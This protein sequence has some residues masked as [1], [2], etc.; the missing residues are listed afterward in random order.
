MQGHSC[1]SY[2]VRGLYGKH[3]SAP[4][5]PNDVIASFIFTHASGILTDGGSPGH[6][7]E[8]ASRLLESAI[9]ELQIVWTKPNG[10]GWAGEL[11]GLRSPGDVIDIGVT[12]DTFS[13]HLRDREP[14]TYLRFGDGEWLS[15]LGREGR[16]SDGQDFAPATLGASSGGRSN[17][18]PDCGRATN[19]S[20]SAYTTATTVV[21]FAA[22]SLNFA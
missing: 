14:F 3:T 5:R 19:A 7:S 10:I 9:S 2:G 22:T 13:A 12:C 15:I 4:G 21:P 20:T 11:P 8:S 17:T 16:T 1:S 6:S 18:R